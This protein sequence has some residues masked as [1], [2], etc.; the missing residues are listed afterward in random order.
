MQTNVCIYSFWIYACEYVFAYIQNEYVQFIYSS[1]GL[2]CICFGPLGMKI[3]TYIQYAGIHIYLSIFT[4]IYVNKLVYMHIFI[5]DTFIP[6][7]IYNDFC[8]QISIYA[9]LYS[10]EPKTLLYI[11]FGIYNKDT[12][13]FR[14]CVWVGYD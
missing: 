4:M 3:C 11:F 14:M 2:Y 7:Y 1:T 9:Y 10:Q 12:S 6:N 13:L 8:K 5:S